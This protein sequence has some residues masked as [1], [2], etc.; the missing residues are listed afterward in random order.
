ML[1]NPALEKVAEMHLILC[2]PL[3]QSEAIVPA[4]V[5]AIARMRLA[6]IGLGA[7]TQSPSRSILAVYA[8]Y[9]ESRPPRH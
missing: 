1:R 9:G 8:P 5:A 4:G 7:A 3:Q 6:L 2:L